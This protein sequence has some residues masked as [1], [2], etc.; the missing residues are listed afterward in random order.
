VDTAD[1]Q[2]L[3]QG[4]AVQLQRNTERTTVPFLRL[5]QKLVVP[6][7]RETS[8]NYTSKGLKAHADPNQNQ[9]HINMNQHEST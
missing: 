4:Y 3:G 6:P 5:A 1:L 2:G 7:S 9:Q 8:C